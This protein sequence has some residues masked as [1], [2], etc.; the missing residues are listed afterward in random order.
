MSPEPAD[1]HSQQEDIVNNFNQASKWEG[2]EQSSVGLNNDYQTQLNSNEKVLL[3]MKDPEKQQLH[4]KEN[5]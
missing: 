3:Q 2:T 5:S 4:S 1:T